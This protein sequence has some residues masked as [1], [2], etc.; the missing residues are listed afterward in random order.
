MR[1]AAGRRVREGPRAPGVPPGSP[2]PF[3][4]GAERRGRPDPDDVEERVRAAPVPPDAATDMGGRGRVS[5][6]GRGRGGIV[7]QGLDARVSPGG[8]CDVWEGVGDSPMVRLHGARE[9]GGVHRVSSWRLSARAIS[10]LPHKIVV[11]PPAPPSAQKVNKYNASGVQ[12]PPASLPHPSSRHA[13]HAAKSGEK[14]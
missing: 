11:V 6:H 7:C 1:A 9:R 14:L 3:P 2:G 8:R 12:T 5:P 4:G 10:R 13:S